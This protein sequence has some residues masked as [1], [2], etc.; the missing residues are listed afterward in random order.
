VSSC[1]TAP[2]NAPHKAVLKI[3][4]KAARHVAD[5]TSVTAA[6]GSPQIAQFGEVERSE[7]PPA[8]LR[9]TAAPTPD[10]AAPLFDRDDLEPGQAAGRLRRDRGQPT[11]S[12]IHPPSCSPFDM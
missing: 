5:R 2:S 9:L 8:R 7:G 12:P 10:V 4:P 6:Y 11:P 3:G 1:S